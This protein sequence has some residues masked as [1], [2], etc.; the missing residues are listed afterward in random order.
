M[1][2]AETLKR[3]FPALTAVEVYDTIDSTNARAIAL[4][5]AGT[6]A[7]ALVLADS[8]SRGRGRVARTFYSPPGTGIYLT[9][10]TRPHVAPALLAHLT[11][12]SA[13]ATAEAIEQVTGAKVGVKW[14]NDLWLG[15]KKITGILVEGAFRPDGTPDYAV[16]G[17]GINVGPMTFPEELSGC[18]TS[19]AD[20]TGTAPDRDALTLALIERLLTRL[21][22][23][24]DGD[25]LDAYRARSVL[26]GR[27]VTVVRGAET[28]DARVLGIDADGALCLSL[29]DG[30]LRT[31]SSG[32]IAHVSPCRK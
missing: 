12:L 25:F 11:P 9:L 26:D 5:K 8:Q 4:A 19:I 15:E 14:V 6:E 3:Q 20:G 16:I 32:E 30:S 18:A 1:L 31:L 17:I 2:T 28:F 10:L 29:P 23:F 27:N 7:P 22:A 13:V 24:P 21:S